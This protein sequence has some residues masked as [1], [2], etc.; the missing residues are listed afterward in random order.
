MASLAGRTLALVGLTREQM[1][2]VSAAIERAG[3]AWHAT[4]GSDPASLGR[5]DLIVTSVAAAAAMK[6]ASKPLL[7]IGAAADI[8]SVPVEGDRPRDFCIAPPLRTEELILRASHLLDHA[9]PKLRASAE[10]PVVLAADDDPTTTA[11]VRAVVT[12]NAMS[13]HTAGDGKRALELAASVDPNVI[14]LDV[15]MPFLDG[16]QVLTALRADPKTAAIPVVMLTSVQQEADV[17]RGF[18]LGADDYIVKPFNPMELLAR[19]R[20]LVKRQS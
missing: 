2:D 14:I 5:V 6:A 18:S 17:V 10:V 4:S 19:I 20:R 9:P 7:I 1:F 15:N 13:C 3:A 8:A 12:K 16:F 11:I